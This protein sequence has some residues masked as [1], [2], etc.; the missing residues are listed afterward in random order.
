MYCNETDA[1]QSAQKKACKKL[2]MGPRS[3]HTNDSA[4]DSANDGH[5]GGTAV[6]T[7]P[8]SRTKTPAFYRVMLINDDFTPMDFVIHVLQKFFSK[9]VTEATK[10]MLEVHNKGAGNCGVF[11][12][13]IAETKVYQVN[14]YARQNRHPL[15]CTMEQA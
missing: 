7:K 13:E 12:Y 8:E 4:N 15:K 14:Q 11:T 3:S 2:M 1:C 10:I 6:I 5:E 9:D